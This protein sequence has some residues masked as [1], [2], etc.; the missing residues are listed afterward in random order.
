MFDSFCKGTTL[1]PKWQDCRR[2]RMP[3]PGD[4]FL[5]AIKPQGRWGKK[6]YVL[7]QDGG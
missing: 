4:S 2:W 6:K 3:E 5:E 7:R 1:S